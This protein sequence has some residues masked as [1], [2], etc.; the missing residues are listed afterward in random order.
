METAPTTPSISAVLFT[1][2]QVLVLMAWVVAVAGKEVYPVALAGRCIHHRPS[3]MVN[4]LQQPLSSPAFWDGRQRLR[5]APRRS[6]STLALG[7]TFFCPPALEPSASVGTTAWRSSS[8]GLYATESPWYR[9]GPS[10]TAAA[11]RYSGGCLSDGIRCSSSRRSSTSSSITSGGEAQEEAR[12]TSTAGATVATSD[13]ARA[14][15]EFVGHEDHGEDPSTSM[16]GGSEMGPCVERVASALEQR[17]SVCGGDLV[18]VLVSGGSDSVALLLALERAAKTF[19]PPLR[20]EAAHFNHGLRGKDS[21]ADQDLV[22]KMA[23][24][25][26]VPLHVRRWKGPEEGGTGGPGSGMQER[27]RRWRRAEAKDI[28]A[29]SMAEAGAGRGGRGVIATAHHKDDQAE[30]VLLKA[31]RGAHITNIQGM[32]WHSDPFVRPLLG[33]HKTE[34]LDFLVGGGHAWREDGSNQVAKYARN[35]VRLQL[36][37]LLREL[38]GGAKALDTRVEELS[39]QSHFARQMVEREALH[40]EREHLSGCRFD[41]EAGGCSDETDQ[42]GGADQSAGTGGTVDRS[43]GVGDVAPSGIRREEFP[44]QAFLRKG[45]RGEGSEQGWVECDLPELVREE[46]LHRFIVANTAN[47]PLSYANL[48][49]LMRQVDGG[50]RKWSISLGGAYNL[51][52]VGGL[53]RVEQSPA[54]G[55]IMVSGLEGRAVS[56]QGTARHSTDAATTPWEMVVSP[57][58]EGG[59]VGLGGEGDSGHGEGRATEAGMVLFNVAA[60]ARLHVRRKKDGDRFRPAWRDRPAKLK[61]FLRGQGVPLHRRD[62]VALI[63]DH[64]DAVIAVY[65]SYP[66]FGVCQDS[67]GEEPIRVRIAG[68]PLF[69][70]RPEDRGGAP[71]S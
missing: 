35:R 6:S 16:A 9:H 2:V 51:R 24:S 69:C 17:C 29:K 61:D 62:E 48:R 19:Q 20:V 59:S 49:L 63:C 53:L 18:L 44:L 41:D 30:T 55:G 12:G 60:G 70:P 68:T 25:L 15:E 8:G 26:R 34:L 71:A 50:D 37:P 54:D 56:E 28:L 5:Q 31:L 36:I 45:P 39:R 22:V 13:K 11:V 57:W 21:D 23:E 3:F 47:S 52:R 67:T 1:Y 40:W 4:T 14:E 7:S 64:H 43:E 66:G 42:V 46:L 33:A 65:P 38:A 58:G 32:A 10:A 27:A